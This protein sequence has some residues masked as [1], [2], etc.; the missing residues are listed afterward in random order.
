MFFHWSIDRIRDAGRCCAWYRN[1]V[2]V[3]ADLHWNKSWNGTCPDE[4]RERFYRA[5]YRLLI[6][7][8][9]L[10]RA[11]NEPFSSSTDNLHLLC[12][13][14][15]DK[16]NADNDNSWESVFDPLARW[17]VG[18][19]RSGALEDCF[20]SNSGQ[21]EWLDRDR[22]HG[23]TQP[24]LDDPDI[25]ALWEVMCMILAYEHMHVKITNADME[26][27]ALGR[28]CPP[29]RLAG[30]TKT[31]RVVLFGIFQPEEIIMP[32]RVEDTKDVFLIARH[33]QARRN[34]DG[35][36]PYS[37]DVPKILLRNYDAI[38]NDDDERAVPPPLQ[39]F[40]YTLRKYFGLRFEELMFDTAWGE[41]RYFRFLRESNLFE[42]QE[43]HTY[44][45]EYLEVYH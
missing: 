22:E 19:A 34:M 41:A 12:P 37:W 17:L 33:N 18:V 28:S 15:M 20:I 4:W 11:Y 2:A 27:G 42:K 14:P 13:S 21:L 24:R 10:C 40:I 26:P 39:F 43:N 29:M 30:P 6:A 3:D 16:P 9:A 36:S 38:V 35:I 32:S 44:G 8:P 31:A 1:G 23:S 45:T 25:F 5:I 7:G